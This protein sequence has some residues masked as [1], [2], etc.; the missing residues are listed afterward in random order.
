MLLRPK[1]KFVCGGPRQGGAGSQPTCPGPQPRCPEASVFVFR[2]FWVLLPLF[3]RCLR[4]G[5]ASLAGAGDNQARAAGL[6]PRVDGV[7]PASLSLLRRQTLRAVNAYL[8][9]TLPC[10]SPGFVALTIRCPAD[11]PHV[12]DRA[13]QQEPVTTQSHWCRGSCSCIFFPVV[14][15]WNAGPCAC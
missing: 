5:E 4:A 1:C 7:P 2:G 9:R 13:R 11:H 10:A 6:F 14:W 3:T 15:G 8:A 12:A